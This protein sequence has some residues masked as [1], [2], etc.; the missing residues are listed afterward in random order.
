MENARAPAC[1]GFCPCAA[2]A[3]GPLGTCV[4]KGRGL[5]RGRNLSARTDG[6]AFAAPVDPS[7]VAPLLYKPQLRSCAFCPFT[8][9][10]C[11]AIRATLFQP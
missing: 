9:A 8:S 10:R 6:F 4:A 1:P 3:P 5:E 7:L 11:C 2:A